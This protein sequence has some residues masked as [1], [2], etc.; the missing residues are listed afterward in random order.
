MHVGE[1]KEDK[2]DC[3]EY[4]GNSSQNHP[5]THSSSG[6][7]GLD[8]S[9]DGEDE[10]Q[11]GQQSLALQHHAD[12]TARCVLC[13]VDKVRCIVRGTMGNHHARKSKKTDCCQE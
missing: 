9:G 12:G 4:S 1:Y 10:S 6:G 7:S 8:I 11:D 3:E 2:D 5:S 13:A